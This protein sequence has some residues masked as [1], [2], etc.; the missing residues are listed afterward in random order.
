VPWQPDAKALLDELAAAGVRCALVTM[1]YRVLAHAVVDAVPDVFEVVVT[2]DE[3]ANGKPHPESYLTAAARLG[4]NVAECVAIEDSP[5]G[6]GSAHA[7]GAVTLAVKRDA[8]LRPLA[9]MSRV[10]TL[11]GIGVDG[12]TRMMAGEVRDDLGDDT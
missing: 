5:A 11:A 7:A 8:P 9:G 12:L 4:V 6:T 2:G 3:V 1:S 10:R